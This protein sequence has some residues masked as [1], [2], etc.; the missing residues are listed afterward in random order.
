MSVRKFITVFLAGVCLGGQS[1]SDSPAPVPAPIPLAA[2]LSKSDE[3]T[4]SSPVKFLDGIP[5]VNADGTANLVVEIPAG[6][7]EK[8]EVKKGHRVFV[9]VESRP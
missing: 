5:A 2:G 3:K 4:I 8:W 9:W 7:N 6:T 1:Y